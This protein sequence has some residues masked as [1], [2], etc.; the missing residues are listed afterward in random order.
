MA[1]IAPMIMPAVSAARTKPHARRPMVSSATTG[2][3]TLSPPL[4][5]ALPTQ[6]PS[7]TTQIQ[8]REMNS[9]QPVRSSLMML[10][11]AGGGPPD[12]SGS[13]SGSPAGQRLDRR[14]GSGLG[15]RLGGRGAGRDA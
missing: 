11:P 1:T 13:G 7:T 14:R 4:S 10:L 12:G 3:S 9:D 5:E 15:R 2:P 8:V 6:K